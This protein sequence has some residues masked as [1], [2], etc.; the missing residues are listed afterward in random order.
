MPLWK[1]LAPIPRIGD[2]F[3]HLEVGAAIRKMEPLP[4]LAPV[5]ADD[6]VIGDTFRHLEPFVRR[7]TPNPQLEE[8]LSEA[9]R[10]RSNTAPLKPSPPILPAPH[11]GPRL[12][13]G[14][15]GKRRP[16]Q[17]HKAE[18]QGY[19][20][21]QWRITPTLKVRG[22][23]GMVETVG[24]KFLRMY[25]PQTLIKWATEV[26]SPGVLKQGRPRK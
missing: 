19:C 9:M 2:T 17:E 7:P 26:A 16:D 18:F 13:L 25:T 12:A 20:I 15:P 5:L 3:R 22:P 4:I 24:G 10:A 21:A 6:L 14:I 11:R 1:K 8:F 23:G